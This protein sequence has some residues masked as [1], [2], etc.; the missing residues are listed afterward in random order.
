MDRTAWP[1]F[2]W[3]YL[4]SDLV[5][6]VLCSTGGYRQVMVVDH[7]FRDDSEKIVVKELRYE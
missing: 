1:C 7:D 5:V 3:S 4:A 2:S 6:L